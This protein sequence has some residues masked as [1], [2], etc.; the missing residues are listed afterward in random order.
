MSK[1]TAFWTEKEVVGL[2]GLKILANEKDVMTEIPE[3]LV[4]IGIN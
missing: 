3:P 2:E 1:L 4:V